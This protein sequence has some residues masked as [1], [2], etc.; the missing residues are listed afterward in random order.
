MK[1][2]RILTIILY[3]FFLASS[4][5]AQHR[6]SWFDKVGVYRFYMGRSD[7]IMFDNKIRNSGIPAWGHMMTKA[8]WALPMTED[9]VNYTHNQNKFYVSHTY[10]CGMA[11]TDTVFYPVDS[12]AARTLEGTLVQ[13]PT[14]IETSPCSPIWKQ[15]LKDYLK[16]MIDVGVDGIFLDNANFPIEH[17]FDQYT[18]AGFKNYL[19]GKYSEIQLVTLYDITSI[20]EFNYAKWIKSHGQRYDWEHL[21][22]EGL[23]EEFWLFTIIADRNLFNELVIYAKDYALENYNKN[24]TI[25]CS[26]FHDVTSK[27]D[28]HWDLVDYAV[29]ESHLFGKRYQQIMNGPIYQT[30]YEVYDFMAIAN[31]LRR[32]I[33]DW[34]VLPVVELEGIGV[35]NYPQTTKNLIKLVFADNYAS[36]GSAHLTFNFDGMENNQLK[37]EVVNFDFDMTGIYSNFIYSNSF[38]FED[39]IFNPGC[40]L[41]YS[42]SSLSQKIQ[43]ESGGLTSTAF[44]GTGQFLID[45][46]IP[47]DVVFAPDTRFFA[48]SDIHLLELQKYKTIILPN[49]MCLNDNQVQVILDYIQNGGT[50]IALGNIGTRNED[51]YPTY[52]VTSNFI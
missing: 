6:P 9:D 22:L 17:L 19:K 50:I 45:N 52:S 44:Y 48:L 12:V 31:K 8:P 37:N 43:R 27:F 40:G 10:Y 28:I 42:M 5:I 34:P 2:L 30:G 32:S 18:M 11:K 51:G 25:S 41:L 15:A 46:S 14:I 13:G 39:L 1:K 26:A 49:T 3:C 21:P 16:D 36:Q 38:L 29:G 35:I 7:A 4:V 23:K 47:F 24:I 20:D 33:K